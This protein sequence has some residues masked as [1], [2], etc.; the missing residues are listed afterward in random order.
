MQI[1]QFTDTA[2]PYHLPHD[3]DLFTW[4]LPYLANKVV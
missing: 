1:K 3:L 4:S 2:T